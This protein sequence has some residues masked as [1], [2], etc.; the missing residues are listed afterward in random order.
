MLRNINMRSNNETH[1]YALSTTVIKAFHLLE[2]IG[3]NQ[4]VQPADIVKAFGFSRANV[5]RM[6]S[7]FMEIGYVEKNEEGYGLTFKL[8]KLGSTV[9]LSCNLRDVSKPVMMELMKVAGEN[10]YLNVLVEDLVIAID[11]IK[12]SHYLTVN[13]DATYTYPVHSCASGKILLSGLNPEQLENFTESLSLTERTKSTI[14]DRTLLLEEVKTAGKNGYALELREWS[15]DLSAI[16]APIYD[17]RQKIVAAISISGPSI[18]LTD[19]RLQDLRIPLMNAAGR[20]SER[21]G[22]GLSI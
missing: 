12:S 2:Y 19:E 13:P 17:Y 8:F 15:D 3:N 6:I 21:L 1:K 5:H 7:T 4:P 18:R 9:P 14:V 10:I 16:A 20:I 11:E 22:K